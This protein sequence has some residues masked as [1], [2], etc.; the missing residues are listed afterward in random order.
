MFP[1]TDFFKLAMQKGSDLRLQK[2]QKK[3]GSPT[4]FW[5]EDAPKNTLNLT[6]WAF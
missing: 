6:N 1:S 2:G 4:S 5:R 3:L